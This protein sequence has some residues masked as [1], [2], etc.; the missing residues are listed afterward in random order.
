MNRLADKVTVEPLTPD[1]IA[2]IEQ[3]VAATLP[4]AAPVRPPRRWWPAPAVAAVAL[5]G[6][7]AFVLLRPHTESESVASST[8][9]VTPAGEGASLSAGD[10]TIDV[11]GGTAAEIFHADDGTIE[12]VLYTGAVECEVPPIEGRPPF[13]VRAGD[14]DVR[15]VGTHFSVERDDDVRVAVTRGKVQVTSPDGV[16]AVAAGESWSRPAIALGERAPSWAVAAVE[17]RRAVASAGVE[18][19]AATDPPPVSPRAANAPDP[20]PER[21]AEVADPPSK[22][23]DKPRRDAGPAPAV[24]A[25]PSSSIPK[26]YGGK[27]TTRALVDA[28]ELE[29]SD[30][31]DAI[32]LY[33]N[34]LSGSEA[35][36]ALY[37]LAYLEY[38]RR[39]NVS[40]ATRYAHGVEKRFPNGD[41]AKHAH[42][43]RIYALHAQGNKAATRAAA[44][45]YLRRDYDGAPHRDVAAKLIDWY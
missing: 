11:A 31:S 38:M 24:V 32:K 17:S 19:S 12:V 25:S 7:F 29:S 42:W 36:Y 13:L 20:A 23:R 2:R 16:V 44:Q 5:A 40:S 15:V 35:E 22:P 6:A 39:D 18:P 28:R 33:Q 37:R 27:P 30:L 3:A 21:L 41:Y 9:V 43:L 26:P 14:V 34:A 8:R 1:R 10:A 45:S 4:A